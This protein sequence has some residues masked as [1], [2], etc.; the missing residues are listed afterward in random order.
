MINFNSSPYSNISRTEYEIYNVSGDM[1]WRKSKIAPVLKL[2]A[3]M[4]R[5]RGNWKNPPRY[6]SGQKASSPRGR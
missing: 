5:L 1:I 4:Q 2:S 3:L 6:R